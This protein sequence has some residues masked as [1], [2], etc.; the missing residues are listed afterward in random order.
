MECFKEGLLTEKDTE[1]IKLEFG[2]SNAMI[3]MLT[4]I[5]EHQG[6]G[7]ILGEGVKKAAEKL[8]KETSKFALHVKGQ[9]IP[10]HEPRL[11]K[12]LGI[13][14]AISPTGADH[15]HNF[16]DTAYDKW[17]DNMKDI[18]ALGCLEPMPANL[19]TPEKIR[20]LVYGS[21][22][23]HLTNSLV[24]CYFT[25]WSYGNTPELVN[26]VTGWNTT[27]W[28]LMKVAERA[29]TMARIFNIREGFKSDDDILPERFS[30]PFKSGPID[31]EKISQKEV[32]HYKEIYYGMMGW[33]EKGIPKTHK[34][35]ELDI[36]WGI[37]HLP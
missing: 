18:Q 14:Y 11:K 33:D 34:L 7:K 31:G 36:G 19:L 29:A 16:H 12:A 30:T 15:C 26:A 6:L 24:I 1:G 5:V 21:N 13:G 25:P 2:N 20:L 8:G 28:E 35:Y 37:D 23:R 22:W 9:E 3:H 4:K 27:T 10:M 32:N 17:N